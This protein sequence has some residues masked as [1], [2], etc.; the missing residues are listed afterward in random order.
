L[1]NIETISTL[2]KACGHS[3]DDL[4]KMICEAVY[5]NCR[6]SG[7]ETTLEEVYANYDKLQRAKT[8]DWKNFDKKGVDE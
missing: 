1:G 6:L 7:S 5:A 2:F 4:R 8:G 3:G